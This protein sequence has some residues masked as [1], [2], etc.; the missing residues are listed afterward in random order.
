MNLQLWGGVCNAIVA[1]F[2]SISGS[3][4]VV[5]F[6]SSFYTRTRYEIIMS[7]FFAIYITYL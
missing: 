7:Q 3:I 1:L 2:C 6:I 4:E 5:V